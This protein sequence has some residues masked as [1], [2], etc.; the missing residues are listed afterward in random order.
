MVPEDHRHLPRPLWMVPGLGGLCVAALPLHVTGNTHITE[1]TKQRFDGKL[2]IWSPICNHCQRAVSNRPPVL[3]KQTDMCGM[4]GVV[5]ASTWSTTRS[6]SQTSTLW[7]C[8]RSVWW[9]I[10]FS[11]LPTTRRTSFGAPMAPAPSGATSQPTLSAPMAPVMVGSTAV[12][13]SHQASGE[14]RATLTTLEI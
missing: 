8:Y 13:C 12:S 11:G 2:R 3:H 10:T 4:F 5:R 7:L 14:W 9:D 6:S 1:K